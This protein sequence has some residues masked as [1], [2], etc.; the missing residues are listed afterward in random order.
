[1]IG[2]GINPTRRQF[3][4]CTGCENA[5]KSWQKSTDGRPWDLLVLLVAIA[6]NASFQN[7]VSNKLIHATLLSILTGYVHFLEPKRCSSYARTYGDKQ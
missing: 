5:L 2:I 3:R 6:Q 4:Y 7:T 1:M